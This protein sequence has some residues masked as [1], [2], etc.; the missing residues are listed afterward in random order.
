MYGDNWAD[1]AEHVGT[2]SQVHFESSFV[3]QSDGPEAVRA[4][5]ASCHSGLSKLWCL[6][7][8]AYVLITKYLRMVKGHVFPCCQEPLFIRRS[9]QSSHVLQVQCVIHF[10]RLPIEDDLVVTDQ[11]QPIGISVNSSGPTI[12]PSEQP[13]P[14]ADTGN[15]IMA[16]VYTLP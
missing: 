7:S 3:C 1:I 4:A 12:G 15:P 14:F 6:F 13:I 10:L 5:N 11:Q 2:R 16:Q 9:S 8:H